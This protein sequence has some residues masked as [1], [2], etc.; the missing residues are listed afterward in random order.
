MHTLID[1]DGNNWNVELKIVKKKLLAYNKSDIGAEPYEIDL[2][3][4][5]VDIT[6]KG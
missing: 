1:T 2:N 5:N 6:L 3:S 4:D